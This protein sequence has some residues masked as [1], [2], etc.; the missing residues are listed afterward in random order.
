MDMEKYSRLVDEFAEANC[1]VKEEDIMRKV[2]SGNKRHFKAFV[3]AAAC[4]ALILIGTTVSAASGLLDITG[5]FKKLFGSDDISGKLIVQ[6]AVQELNLTTQ[7]DKYTITFE[8]IVGD[9]NT[10]YGV[11]K[12]VDHYG[13]LGN[14]TLLK[15]EV[16]VLDKSK[17]DEGRLSEYISYPD[18][19]FSVSDEEENTYYIKISRPSFYDPEDDIYVSFEKLIA[20]YGNIEYVSPNT[21]VVLKADR[22][23]EIPVN[24]NWTYTPDR[25]IFP[26]STQFD[27]NQVFNTEYG[28]F[29]VKSLEASNYYTEIIITFPTNDNILD[30]HDAT[31]VWHKFDND[32][33]YEPLPLDAEPEQLSIQDSEYRIS[34]FTRRLHKN[35]IGRETRYVKTVKD[36]SIYMEGEVKLF[37][38]GNEIKRLMN[39]SFR[40]A[41]GMDSEIN[42]TYWGNVL[43]FEPFDMRSAKS[44]EIRYKDQIIEVK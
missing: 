15:A 33:I 27:I 28:E 14:P 9:E 31:S 10:Q 8:G 29:T 1:H 34:H 42:P 40:W 6:G 41:S 39:N 36:P 4:V 7:N 16:I 23:V 12:V 24:M 21:S 13:E 17:V 2:H 30:V 19:E 22:T 35:D 20:Y 5:L 43:Q 32:Y 38:N 37:V 25:D 3:T 26:K 44:I 18:G 11:F